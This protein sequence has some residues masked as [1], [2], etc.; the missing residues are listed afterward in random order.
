VLELQMLL[1]WHR[2]LQKQATAH[3]KET[4]MRLGPSVVVPDLTGPSTVLVK[5]M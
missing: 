2:V 5:T 1:R 3:T 4:P